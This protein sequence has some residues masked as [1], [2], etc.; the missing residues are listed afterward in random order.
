MIVEVSGCMLLWKERDLDV[1]LNRQNSFLHQILN[2][3]IYDI[4]SG[5]L[6]NIVVDGFFY[7][8]QLQSAVSWFCGH[9]CVCFCIL[10]SRDISLRRFLTYLTRDIG[11]S[12]VVMRGAGCKIIND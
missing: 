12:G 6:V 5:P 4:V 8:R 3:N 1:E 2:E 9:Y 11:L 7:N 10:R